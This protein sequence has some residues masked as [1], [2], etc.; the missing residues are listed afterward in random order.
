M[1]RWPLVGRDEELAF[2]GAA[3]RGPGIVI[4]GGAGVGKTRLA[5]ELLAQAAADGAPVTRILCTPATADIPLGALAHL[6]PA[7]VA[8][9]ET[10]L[11]THRLELLRVLRQSVLELA[12]AQRA[13]LAVD[14]AHL[15]DDTGA[16]ALLQ[17]VVAGDATLLATIRSG[18]EV[19]APVRSL[20]RDAGCER[21]ELQNLAE[22]EVRMLLEAVTGGPVAASSVTRLAALTRGNPLFLREVV[23]EAMAHGTLAPRH[24]VW[25]WSGALPA[26]APLQELVAERLGRLDDDERSTVALVAAGEPLPLEL[27]LRTVDRQSLE[28]LE[29]AGLLTVDDDGVRLG[30]P[31]HGE[32][33]RA[34]DR[35]TAAAR[36]RLVALVGDDPPPELRLRVA[37][38]ALRSGVSLP[39]RTWLAACDEARGRGDDE[40]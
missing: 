13:M 7:P 33:L 29:V 6:L 23:V 35:E 34:S 17:L 9:P 27:L 22:G 3:L 25:V 39:A 36:R 28:R 26:G 38:W 12:G 24:G 11:G 18:E 31:L 21:L 8:P 5:T 19:P 2:A 4:A 15:L 14:D 30:H 10:V 32:V 1:H 20:W 40:L 37:V 16:A